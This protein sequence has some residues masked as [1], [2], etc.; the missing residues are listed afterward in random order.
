MRIVERAE[1]PYRGITR[2]I[3]MTTFNEIIDRHPEVFGWLE[4]RGVEPVGAPFFRYHVVDM[5]GRLEV[6]AGVPVPPG[7]AVPASDE[8]VTAG[9]LPAG[10][11]VVTTHV[12][13]PD[14]LVETTRALLEWAE[15]HG[16]EF[17]HDGDRWVSRLE[18]Y[19][20]DPADE[21]DMNKWEVE[22]AF[23]LAG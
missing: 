11:Y 1:Q 6:E 10:R 5:D 2:H 17:D 13:H 14:Q 7:S 23:K 4:V 8:D 3:T 9:V 21:P 12:G 22:L 16:E 18:F 15:E 19:N 20:T